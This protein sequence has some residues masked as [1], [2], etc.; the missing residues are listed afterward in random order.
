MMPLKTQ[1]YGMREFA[2]TDP[3]GH[4]ITFAERVARRVIARSPLWCWPRRWRRPKPSPPAAS[5]RSATARL[6]AGARATAVSAWRVVFSARSLDQPRV[7]LRWRTR[8]PS[9]S[10]TVFRL[11]FRFRERRAHVDWRITDGAVDPRLHVNHGLE[12]NVERDLDPAV[13]LHEHPGRIAVVCTIVDAGERPRTPGERASEWLLAAGVARSVNLFQSTAGRAYAVQTIVGPRADARA[14][15][16]LHSRPICVGG[17]GDAA[18]CAVRIRRR[19]TASASRRWCGAGTFR[20]GR[21]GRR[22]ASCRWAD[23]GRRDPIPEDTSRGNFT[24]H[25]GGGVRLRP[26]GRIAY[27]SLS[28]S[29]LLER[30][31]AGIESRRQQ[32]RGV[33]RMVTASRAVH[34]S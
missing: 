15:A 3:D 26:R 34:R 29:A 4:I 19:S 30:Q 7:E 6:V 1:F 13:E 11:S 28:L 33:G 5:R 22:L 2:V 8:S 12:V 17:R 20:R 24:A 14:G 18:V 10:P 32:P 16:G 21:D 25:W 31:P 27:W 23:C 9:I